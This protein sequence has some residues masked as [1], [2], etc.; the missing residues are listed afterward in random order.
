[1]L[2]NLLNSVADPDADEDST[3]HPDAVLDADPDTGFITWIRI[4]LFTLM[5]IRIQILAFK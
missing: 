3:Y 2:F 1:L 5:W 4:R